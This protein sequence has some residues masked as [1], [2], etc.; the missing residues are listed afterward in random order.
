MKHLKFICYSNGVPKKSVI[1]LT[2]PFQRQWFKHAL[3]LL[4]ICLVLVGFHYVRKNVN[5]TIKKP[6]KSTPQSFRYFWLCGFLG[7][8]K[9]LFTYMRRDTQ[10]RLLLLC[11]VSH[12]ICKNS[13]WCKKSTGKGWHC[14]IRVQ[15]CSSEMS[16]AFTPLHFLCKDNLSQIVAKNQSNFSICLLVNLLPVKI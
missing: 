4:S 3:H 10:P 12:T 15:K 14:Y 2:I 6:C 9:Y 5:E 13:G 7:N 16:N 1:T 8:V 11:W